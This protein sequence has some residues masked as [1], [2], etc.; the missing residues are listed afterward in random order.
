[1]TKKWALMYDL[2]FHDHNKWDGYEGK[3]L[4]R[5]N[6]KELIKEFKELKDR[7][8][9]VK[10]IRIVELTFYDDTFFDSFPELLI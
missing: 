9:Y 7:E 8:K 4:L 1:M 5:N 10:N 3:P 6:P 2:V